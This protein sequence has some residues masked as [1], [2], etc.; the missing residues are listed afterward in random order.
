LGQLRDEHDA[1]LPQEETR[2]RSA[3][4]PDESVLSQFEKPVAQVTIL[5]WPATQ[6]RVT[7]LASAVLLQSF[8]QEPHRVVVVW[9]FTSQ[10]FK[11]E[12]SQ[13]WKPVLQVA[14]PHWPPE[15]L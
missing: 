13:F 14:M 9:T 5:H 7:T 11:L 12:P 3:S 15:Q 4:H 6:L 10:P 2:E 8:E 1:Q